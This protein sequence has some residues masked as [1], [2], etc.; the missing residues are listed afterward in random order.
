MKLIGGNP[1]D[2]TSVTFDK[3]GFKNLRISAEYTF[4]EG[5]LIDVNTKRA[6]SVTLSCETE[7]GWSDWIADVKFNPFYISGF[8]DIKFGP[9]DN[10]T[11]MYYDHSDKKNPA[12]IPS[13]Y[14]NSDD[15][16]QIDTHLPTWRGFYIPSIGLTLPAAFSSEGGNPIVVKAEKLIFDGGL[17]GNVSINNILEIGKGSL[18]G[19][20]YSIDRFQ[21]DIWKNS[22]KHQITWILSIAVILKFRSINLSMY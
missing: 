21:I 14:K 15:T 12:G 6:A 17:S 8:E 13:P 16:D 1:L 5:S 19:W 11:S 9:D 20:Y 18:D 22:F 2:A 7:D 4:P 3:K 10:N